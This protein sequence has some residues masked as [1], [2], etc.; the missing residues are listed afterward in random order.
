[1]ISFDIM[2]R[3]SNLGSGS[4]FAASK[5]LFI[6]SGSKVSSENVIADGFL[7]EEA[8]LFK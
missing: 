6:I 1:M 8:I 3:F 5:M 7:A 4:N 2:N